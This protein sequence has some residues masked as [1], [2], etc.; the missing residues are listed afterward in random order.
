M[1]SVGPS[2]AVRLEVDRVCAWQEEMRRAVAPRES[3]PAA[4][5]D[6]IA[7]LLERFIDE[8]AAERGCAGEVR[9][10]IALLRESS[11][12]NGSASFSGLSLR[13]VG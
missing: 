13:G 4:A 11:Q 10:A 12:R 6:A 9:L 2:A 7:L 1:R 5:C 8:T 3:L